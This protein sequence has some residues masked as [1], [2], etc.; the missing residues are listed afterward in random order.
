MTGKVMIALNTTWNL[1]NFRS[2]IIKALVVEGYEVVAVAPRDEYVPRLISLGCRFVA[3]PMDSKG[4]NPGRD[5][6]LL[7]RFFC[8]LRR[9][10]PAVFL[11]YTVKPNVHGSLAA[12][13]LGIPVVNNI[14]GLGSVF[15]RNGWLARLV[16]ALYRIALMR[17]VK[18]FFQNDEDRQMFL[19]GGLVRRE[20]AGLLP[21]SGVDLQRFALVPLPGRA[22][23]RFV[24]IARML[25][26]KGVGEYVAA[27]RLLRAKGVEAEFFL[28]G[29]LDVENPAAISTKQV[30]EWVSEG[31]VHYLGASDDVV[32]VIAQAD[33]IVLPSYREGT[34][35][36]LLEAAAMGRPIVAT[37]AVG[38]R[39][40]VDDGM[41]GFLC[42]VRD[43]ADLAEK[44]SWIV[45]MPLSKR[46]EMGRWGRVKVERQFD[47]RFVIDKYREVIR[48]VV[49]SGKAFCSGRGGGLG[50]S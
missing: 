35:K 33:C 19:A 10:R 50:S 24:L 2:G 21:G 44:M 3:L 36:V 38:C 25:W 39:E 4:T 13:A 40:V 9:E 20:I 1:V 46:Q 17:S 31:S 49:G 11:A 12:H 47:E 30:E 42:R 41:N 15:I 22:V 16:C 8:L 34:P 45:A 43:V 27:A 5:L 32:D 26:D 48:S 7:W 29:F 37:D 18:V 28:L 14:A 23:A 6:M